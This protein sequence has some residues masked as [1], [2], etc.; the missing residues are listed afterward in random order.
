MRTKR[1]G[2]SKDMAEWK[3]GTGVK[4]LSSPSPNAYPISASKI[5]FSRSITHSLLPAGKVW[6]QNVKA[7]AS[8]PVVHLRGIG[9]GVAS[10]DDGLALEERLVVGLDRHMGG[11]LHDE[12]DGGRPRHPVGRVLRRAG[13]GRVVM[14]LLGGE[15][16]LGDGGDPLGVLDL[17]GRV[18]LPLGDVLVLLARPGDLK[19]RAWSVSRIGSATFLLQF[20]QLHQQKYFP[21]VP[22]V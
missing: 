20:L 6:D 17:L 3:T 1:N 8:S 7:A 18:H 9:V 5:H 22:R 4:L 13:Q 11:V 10:E 15:G 2:R 19:S 14:L 16:Q 12:V 21:F